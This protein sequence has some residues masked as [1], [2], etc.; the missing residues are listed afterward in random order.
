MQETVSAVIDVQSLADMYLLSEIACDPDL[1]WSSFYLSLDMSETGTGKVIFEAPWDKDSAFGIKNGFV[2]SGEGVYA[3]NG[4]NPWLLLLLGQDWF[5][6]LV[7]EKWQKLNTY[8]VLKNSLSLVEK[9]KTTYADAYAKNYA[10]WQSR[11]EF[12]NDELVWELNTYR[13]QG[14]AADYLSRWLHTRL[15]FLNALWG[16]GGDV[17]D[18][19]STDLI[20]E[21]PEAGAKPYRFEAE[22]CATT[23]NIQVGDHGGA[24]GGKY[25]GYVDM[26]STITLTVRAESAVNAYLYINLGRRSQSGTFNEWFTVTVN[27]VRQ[28][29]PYRAIGAISA[30]EEEWYAWTEIKVAPIALKAGVNTVV[31]TVVASTATNVDRF[32]LYSTVPLS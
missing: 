13:T 8:G 9:Y 10:R 21:E 5:M 3:G 11:I 15:N 12:G 31:F 18:G 7:R 32:T 20:P 14:E 22:D 1:G 29:V 2:N 24:S 30:G 16:N 26:G 17:S 25:L 23:G 19:G 4:S 27:G 28:S 6:D